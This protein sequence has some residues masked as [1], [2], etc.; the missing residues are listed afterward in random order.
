MPK[1]VNKRPLGGWFIA[2]YLSFVELMV[3]LWREQ[4]TGLVPMV[5][6]LFLIAVVLSFLAAISPI[7]PFVYPLF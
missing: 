4:L 1:Q 7:A 3:A 2:L 5:L 6:V